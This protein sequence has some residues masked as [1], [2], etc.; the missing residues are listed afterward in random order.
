M[1]N[2]RGCPEL[3]NLKYKTIDNPGMFPSPI[4]DSEQFLGT[5]ITINV[6]LNGYY[7]Y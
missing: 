5:I 2:D 4:D 3:A 1:P 6:V 7:I